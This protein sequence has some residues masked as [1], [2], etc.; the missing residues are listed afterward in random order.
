M[1]CPVCRIQ[2]AGTA[3]H[4]RVHVDEHLRYGFFHKDWALAARALRSGAVVTDETV[5]RL[6]AKDLC[7]IL[8]EDADL[9]V[10]VVSIKGLPEN[11]FCPGVVVRGAE[12]PDANGWY[13]D[14]VKQKV[15]GRRVFLRFPRAPDGDW[16]ITARRSGPR[17]LTGRAE[18]FSTS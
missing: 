1:R 13:F 15:L 7:P 14:S 11:G 4:L 17:M 12:E 9:L 8:M 16:S 18:G 5:A 2:I 6:K 10:A 3:A